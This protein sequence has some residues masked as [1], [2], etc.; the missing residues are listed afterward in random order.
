MLRNTVETKYC[1]KTQ[2][3]GNTSSEGRIGNKKIG[4]K[5]FLELLPAEAQQLR[6]NLRD[7]TTDSKSSSTVTI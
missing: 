6:I 5:Q 2:K 7:S 1:W 3:L 4:K